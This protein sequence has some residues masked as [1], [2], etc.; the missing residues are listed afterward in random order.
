VTGADE[1]DAALREASDDINSNVSAGSY[2]G[3]INI[4]SASAS[5]SEYVIGV[6]MI[7]AT[8]IL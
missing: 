5:L 1:L 6:A 2:I 4:Q 8:R 7:A 3:I